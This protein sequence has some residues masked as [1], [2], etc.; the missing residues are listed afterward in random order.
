M[1]PLL[2]RTLFFLSTTVP[3]KKMFTTRYLSADRTGN[4][5]LQNYQGKLQPG[6]PFVVEGEAQ[7][8]LAG[9]FPTLSPESPV[10]LSPTLQLCTDM[11]DLSEQEL[12]SVAKAELLRLQGAASKSYRLEADPRVCVISRSAEDLDRFV[13]T[14]GGVLEIY[15]LLIDGRHPDYPEIL[16]LSVA[17]SS[18]GCR[19]HY[20]RRSPFNAELCTYCGACS[21]VCDEHCIS[22]RLHIDYSRCTFCKKC[23]DA[24]ETDALDIYGAEEV[25]LNLPAL[26]LLQGAAPELPED[27]DCVYSYNQ[28]E[29]YFSTLFSADITEVV[30]HNN[31]ICQYSGRL[32]IGC[33]RCIDSCPHGALTAGAQGIEVDPLLCEECGNCVGICPTGAMDYSLFRDDVLV[34]YLQTLEIDHGSS[35][36]IG[37]EEQLQEL[38]WRRDKDKKANTFFL[39]Y[40]SLDFLSWFHFLLLFARGFS[41][42]TVVTGSTAHP[43][44]QLLRQADKAN[45]ITTSLFGRKIV[46]FAAIDDVTLEAGGNE[47]HPLE[48]AVDLK[49]PASRKAMLSQITASLITA[50]GTP[51]AIEETAGDFFALN[52]KT[53]ACSQCLACLNECRTTALKAQEE[54]L[55][56]TH[57]AGLCV[58][59]G[60]CVR[61]C[62]ENALSLEQAAVVD[63]GYFARREL[64]RA[65]AAHCKGCG[66]VFGT[67]QSLDR[68]LQILSARE[69]INR[70][71]FEYCSDCRVVQIFEAEES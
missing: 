66:K 13:D 33:A 18:Q 23:E 54:K 64:A 69:S 2:S 53:S 12:L 25:V 49:T 38:W 37:G 6:T 35:L 29:T 4:Y 36:I 27:L 7:V 68:V 48:A 63:A 31:S 24:C 45:A 26:I 60:I 47:R 5:A 21:D 30:C 62:P 17:K 50:A 28:L 59:C 8:L 44:P 57:E 65:E 71:H 42:I 52:C 51:L 58:G 34:N 1:L 46:E 9:G 22:P 16:Q 70:D 67:R 14:Y 20:R 3:M 56:L 39:E 32:E 15:P 11:S 40:P 10:P 43:P 55:T 61:V 19:V 41:T